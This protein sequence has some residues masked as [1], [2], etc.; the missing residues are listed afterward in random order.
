MPGCDPVEPDL[1]VVGAHQPELLQKRIEGVPQL[2]VEVLSPSH[3]ELDQ[4]IKYAAYARADLPEYWMIRPARRE[5]MMCWQPSGDGFLQTRTFAADEE[6]VSATLP[7]RFPVND[8]FAGAPN[9]LV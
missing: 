9:T 7:I 3:P 1:T 4:V 8:L 6:L 2:I 5:A